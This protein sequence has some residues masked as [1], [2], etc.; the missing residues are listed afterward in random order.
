MF[1]ISFAPILLA[2]VIVASMFVALKIIN[3]KQ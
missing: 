2:A 1:G 3:K